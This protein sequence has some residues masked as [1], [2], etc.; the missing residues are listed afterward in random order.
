M[1]CRAIQ[2]LKARGF[3][4]G[5]QQVGIVQSGRQPIW[6]A[7]STHAIQVGHR[8]LHCLSS[9]CACSGRSQACMDALVFLVSLTL[10]WYCASFTRCVKKSVHQRS[11]CLLGLPF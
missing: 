11:V 1:R 4:R 6:R 10:S 5:G 9:R 3:L 7:A 2:E 8:A